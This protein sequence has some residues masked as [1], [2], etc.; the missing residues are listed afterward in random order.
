MRYIR[1]IVAACAAVGLASPA[2]AGNSLSFDREADR[3]IVVG[4]VP[5][6]ALDPERR[7][8]GQRDSE[9]DT[10]AAPRKRVLPFH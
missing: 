4:Q 10:E 7:H 2:L 8:D 1:L 9:R 3:H 6:R 5:R